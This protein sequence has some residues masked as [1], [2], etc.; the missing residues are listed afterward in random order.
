MTIWKFWER[1]NLLIY[2]SKPK[3]L[4]WLLERIQRADVEWIK[5]GFHTQKNVL[6]KNYKYPNGHTIVG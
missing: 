1:V 2:D 4:A 5:R 6:S 3:V